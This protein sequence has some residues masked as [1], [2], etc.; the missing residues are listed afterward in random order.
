MTR[1]PLPSFLLF[2]LAG[3]L[4][5][6]AAN[7]QLRDVDQKI[8]EYNVAQA[9]EAL[10]R[11]DSEPEKL[12]AEGRILGLEK[13]WAEGEAKLAKAAELA[14]ADAAIWNHL[15]ELRERAGNAAG[16][17]DAYQRA[18]D[19][20]R[21][22]VEGGGGADASYQLGRALQGLRS[23]DA[24]AEQLQKA[25]QGGAPLATY[26]LGVVRATQERWQESLDV[27]TQAIN[28]N[29]GIAYAYYY[30]GLAA[31]KVNRK[32]LLINDLDRFLKLAPTA[33][34]ADRVRRMLQ[35]AKR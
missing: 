31:S 35:S 23:F 9:R 1:L 34:E 32:D 18:S 22:Q 5:A 14:G 8:L 19:L 21:K 20:A 15:G 29:S 33:P 4:T 28:A 26:H 12:A 2:L 10:A 16:A 24:A 7:A 6:A 13:K 27:L 3:A 11:I 30:R 25:Q 17:R